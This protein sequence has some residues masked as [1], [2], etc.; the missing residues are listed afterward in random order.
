MYDRKV[1]GLKESQIALQAIFEA[2]V[3]T[4]EEPPCTAVVVD[5]HG[6]LVCLMRMDGTRDTV[7]QMAIKKAQC[8]TSS[9]NDSSKVGEFLR[10]QNFE[11]T[12]FSGNITKVPGG[13]R[14]VEPNGD[15][16]TIYGAIAVSGQHPGSEDE[17]LA[18]IGLKALQK[19]GPLSRDSR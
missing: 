3:K 6:D 10:S 2:V 15:G 8:V 11:N 18:F 13:V 17:E 9:L 4:P 5:H 12:D 7:T 1:L 16:R 19:A 14:I